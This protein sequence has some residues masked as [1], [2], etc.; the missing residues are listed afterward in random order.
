M[1]KTEAQRAHCDWQGGSKENNA[2]AAMSAQAAMSG[3]VARAEN[4]S[5]NQTNNNLKESYLSYLS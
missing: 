5:H 4:A 1:S 2:S 3:S